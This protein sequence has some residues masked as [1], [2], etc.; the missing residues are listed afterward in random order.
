MKTL[1][2]IITLITSLNIHAQVIEFEYDDAGNR[3]K[4]KLCTMCTSARPANPND[5]TN[6]TLAANIQPNPT[7]G[8]LAIEVTETTFKNNQE[9]VTKA[10]EGSHYHVIV[11]DLYG[12]E[13]LNEQHTTASFNVD[14]TQQTKG[15]YFVKLVSGEK[16]KQWK[17]VKD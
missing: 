13:V 12:R 14:I 4:R 9:G 16:V 15:V 6:T 8:N 10:S 3:V 1:I 7:K 2:F 17:I 5:T 11:Y